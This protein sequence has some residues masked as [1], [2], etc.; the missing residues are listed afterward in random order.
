MKT[1]RPTISYQWQS[2]ASFHCWQLLGV[3]TVTALSTSNSILGLTINDSLTS[4][5]AMNASEKLCSFLSLRSFLSLSLSYISNAYPLQ[6]PYLF[7]LVILFS[8]LARYT[9]SSSALLDKIH[10]TAAFLTNEYSD[11][12]QCIMPKLF[13]A[14]HNTFYSRSFHQNIVE[15]PYVQINYPHIFNWQYT[16]GPCIS[17]GGVQESVVKCIR[18]S[19]KEMV[20]SKL[21]S[22]QVRPDIITRTCNDQPCPPRWNISEFGECSKPCGGGTQV[23]VGLK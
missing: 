8:H 18:I 19:D 12:F 15:T 22:K 14:R 21:C 9:P 1:D 3:D 5:L 23:T 6:E 11:N 2:S 13:E 7:S 4:E 20:K 16:F 10:S 17:S